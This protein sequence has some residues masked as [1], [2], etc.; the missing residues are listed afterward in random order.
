MDESMTQQVEQF[1]DQL[2]T[3]LLTVDW[4]EEVLSS[5]V[6]NPLYL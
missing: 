4:R 2:I 1:K 5:N 6:Y 3:H